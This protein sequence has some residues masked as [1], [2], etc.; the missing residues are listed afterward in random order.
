MG[1]RWEVLLPGTH[2]ARLQAAAEECL[3]EVERL[4]AQ[5]SAFRWESELSGIN[6]RAGGEPVRVE[7]RLFQFLLRAKELSHATGGAFDPTV[8]PL[9][10]SWGFV[11]GEGR[12]PH[13]EE[14]AAAR[15]LTGA[16]MLDLDPEAY[17]LRFAQPGME[18]DLGAI[19]KGYAVDR[20]IDVLRDAGVDRALLHAGTSTV[21][22]LGASQDGEPGSSAWPIALRD[23]TRDAESPL[24]RISLRDRALSV[25]AP[26]GKSFRH[27]GR[28]LG[29]VLDPRSGEPTRGAL[30][31]AAVHSSAMLTDALSTALLVLGE[32]GLHLL[33][34]RFPEADLLVVGEHG[35][36][37]IGS[38]T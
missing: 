14:V 7:P 5:L 13:P 38:W 22:G 20:A 6:A 23:P 27:E 2:H 9:L 19:G 30:L 33:A 16:P 21:Y 11:G 32:E 31:A 8:R 24:K 12:F 18:L 29:H 15:K 37:S 3:D 36:R 1:T 25:S 4:D 17:T 10:R 26:H 28:V 34:E 35:V